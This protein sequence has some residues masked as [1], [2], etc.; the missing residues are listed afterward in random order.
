MKKKSLTKRIVSFITAVGLTLTSTVMLI[1]ASAEDSGVKTATI[2][3]TDNWSRTLDYSEIPQGV[4]KTAT[5]TLASDWSGSIDFTGVAE[6]NDT[7]NY[8]TEPYEFQSWDDESTPTAEIIAAIETAAGVDLPEYPTIYIND[9]TVSYN[10]N[11][12]PA[13]GES[14][15]NVEVTIN[16]SGDDE[17]GKYV[18]DY[19]NTYT[20]ESNKGSE[21]IS[22]SQLTNK[23]AIVNPR[24]L[25]INVGALGK[26][27]NDTFE[28]NVTEIKLDVTYLEGEHGAYIGLYDDEAQSGH[29][30]F[31]AHSPDEDDGDRSA[32]IVAAIKEET[33]DDTQHW[34][35]KITGMSVDYSWNLT[36][37]R[38]DFMIDINPVMMGNTPAGTDTWV[39]CDY[40]VVHGKSYKEITTEKTGTGTFTS[41]DLFNATNITVEDIHCVDLNGG[42]YSDDPDD[43]L[44]VSVTSITLDVEYTIEKPPVEEYISYEEM[45][46]A[47]YIEVA[48]NVR[49]LEDCE[50]DSHINEDSGNDDAEGKTYCPWSGFSINKVDVNDSWSEN[51]YDMWAEDN[52]ISFAEDGSSF[53]V[54]VPVSSVVD[55]LGALSSGEQYVISTGGVSDVSYEIYTSK[56]DMVLRTGS[57]LSGTIEYAYLWDD[58]AQGPVQQDYPE[59][60]PRFVISENPNAVDFEGYAALK[61]DYTATNPTAARGIGILF[62]GWDENGIGWVEK[63]FAM[64]ENGTIAIDLTSDMFEGKSF[65]NIHIGP[66]A[67]DGAQVGDTLAPGFAVTSA[68]IVTSYDGEFSEEL[69]PEVDSNVYLFAEDIAGKNYLRVTANIKLLTECE[70]ESHYDENYGVDDAIG[71]TYCPWNGVNIHKINAD[72]EWSDAYY[73]HWG[74][75]N[76][77]V[78]YS[79]DKSTA[80]Y[81]Y[82]IAGIIDA[83]GELEEGDKYVILTDGISSMTYELLESKPDMTLGT[84]SYISGTIGEASEWDN[85]TNST[86]N[87]GIPEIYPT[88]AIWSTPD[89]AV[90]LNG[91]EALKIDYTATNPEAARGINL[92]IQG[93]GDNSTEWWS[94]FYAIEE[95]GSIVVDLSAADLKDKIFYNI[96]VGPVAPA[97]AEIGDTFAP[98]FTVTSAALLASYDGTFSEEIEQPVLTEYAVNCSA[99]ANGTVTSDFEAAPIGRTVTLTLTPDEG[100]IVETVT[101]MNGE[102][103]VET[104]KVNSKT[105]TFKMPANDVTVTAAFVEGEESAYTVSIND[106]TG[107]TITATYADT[108]NEGKVVEGA[109]VTLSV[110]LTSGYAFNN[111][112]TVTDANGSAVTVSIEKDANNNDV[113]YFLMPASDV[114]VTGTYYE[115][116]VCSW[117]KVEDGVYTL[118]TTREKY[119]GDTV[120]ALDIELAEGKTFADVKS[121]KV[122]FEVSEGNWAGGGL[123]A[124]G[125]GEASWEQVG[126]S[127]PDGETCGTVTLEPANGFGTNDDAKAEFQIWWIGAGTITATVSIEYK[128]SGSE[129]E[130]TAGWVD[131]EDGSYTYTSVLGLPAEGESGEGKD[132]STQDATVL[133]IDLD[134]Y[135]QEGA[136]RKYISK[137]TADIEVNGD[138]GGGLCIS[139]KNSAEG[140][141]DGWKQAEVK[142]TGTFTLE[143]PN[144]VYSDA[145]L[146]FMMWFA[147]PDTSLTVSNI[148]LEYMEIIPAGWAGDGEGTYTYTSVLGLPNEDDAEGTERDPNTEEATVLVIDLDEYLE[149]GK[150]RQDIAKLTA[151]FVVDDGIGGGFCIAA[152][153]SAE[154][155]EDGWTEFTVEKSGTFSLET[156]YGVSDESNLLFLMWWAEADT[157][158]TISNIQ[159]EYIKHEITIDKAIEG[160]TVETAVDAAE[161]G[162]TVVITVKPDEG[163]KLDR[164]Y[165]VYTDEIGEEQEIEAETGLSGYEFEMPSAAVEI[166]AVFV[167]EDYTLN[168]YAN[169]D[170]M[171]SVSVVDADGFVLDTAQFGDTVYLDY[172]VN[173]NYKFVEWNV[174]EGN[175]KIEDAEG[176]FDASFTMPAGN[177][178]IEAVFRELG[179]YEIDIAENENGTVNVVESA[180][181]D[182]E[183][184]FTVNA[185]EGYEIDQVTYSYNKTS[186]G[187]YAD[188]LEADPDDGSYTFTMPAAD[189]IISVSYKAIDY[190]VTVTKSDNGTV[191]T[192]AEDNLANI[193]DV[194]TITIEPVEGYKLVENSIEVLD[195]NDIDVDFEA[196]DDGT[197][198][199][200]MPASDVTITAEFEAIDYKVSVETK[201]EGVVEADTDIANIGNTVTFTATPD[202]SESI[203]VVRSV[204]VTYTRGDE[205][206]E[207][208][209]AKDSTGVYAFTMPAADVTISVVFGEYVFVLIEDDEAI[210]FADTW[211]EIA[212]LIEDGE[213]T[214]VVN[215]DYEFG[216]KFA[217]PKNAQSLTFTGEGT[218]T[219]TG[220]KFAVPVDTTF[221]AKVAVSNKTNLIDISVAKDCT[222]ELTSDATPYENS[223]PVQFINKITGT[224]TSKLFGL[225]LVN[226]IATF[227]EVN[228]AFEEG[229]LEVNGGKAT[230]IV[231]LGG[232]FAIIG[233]KATAAITEVADGAE[234][235]L[236]INNTVIP[237]VTIDKFGKAVGVWVYDEDK[238]MTALPSGTTILSSKNPVPTGD[239]SIIIENTTENGEELTAYYY[240]KTKEIKAEYGEALYLYNGETEIGHYPNFELLL[241]EITD[242][243]VDYTIEVKTDLTL[244]EKFALPK[245][246]GSITFDGAGTLTFTGTKL[247]VPYDVTIGDGI[248]IDV[249]NKKGTFDIA[250]AKDAKLTNEGTIN[251]INKLSGTKTSALVGDYTAAN[252][253]TFELVDGEITVNGGKVTGIITFDGVLMI[254]GAKA[255]AAITTVAP[256]S[257][258]LLVKVNNVLPKV[259][260]EGVGGEN[261]DEITVTVLNSFDAGDMAELESGT[262]ILYTKKNDFTGKLAIGNDASMNA[263][264]YGKEIK[265]EY[266]DAVTVDDLGTEGDAENANLEKDYP[267]FESAVAA[268]NAAKNNTANY[269]ITINKDI[270]PAKF[271]LPKAAE[272]ITLSGE[273][274]TVN[275]GKAT[276]ITANTDLN[277][278]GITFVTTGKS[279]TLNAKK[280]LTV[281][282]IY[283]DVSAIKGSAKFGLTWFGYEETEPFDITGFGTVEVLDTLKIGKN[284]NVTKLILGT[285]DGAS[286]LLVS[287]V[288]AK[289][290]IKALDAA[291]GGVIEYAEG[292]KIAL[293]FTGKP[294]DFVVGDGLTITGAVA[295]GQ[296]VLATDKI[297]VTDLANGVIPENADVE[298]DF[299][300]I[301]KNICY[302]GKV[303]EVTAGTEAEPTAYALWS[304][305]VA[306]MNNASTEYTITLLDDY[307]ENGAVKFPKTGTYKSVRITSDGEAKNFNFSGNLTLTADTTFEDVNIGAVKN[308][309]PVKYTINAG[310]N[311]VSL[312]NCGTG[313]LTSVSGTAEVGLYNITAEKVKA[314]NLTMGGKIVAKGGITAVNV[315][316]YATGAELVMNQ[317]SKLAVS[318]NIELAPAENALGITATI[319]NKTTGETAVLKDGE[320]IGT[321]KGTGAENITLNA[322]KHPGFKVELVKGKLVVKTVA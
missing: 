93:W 129:P 273:N 236:E 186:G 285:S 162:E 226:N 179:S 259:T 253:A 184:T 5:A 219:F 81:L 283:G 307:T 166:R 16:P 254:G 31:T 271:E 189:V 212:E 65:N 99:A 106:V 70:H 153:E 233:D 232:T 66:L 124:N 151:D 101:V 89:A 82:P 201:G 133:V 20:F 95:S 315:R 243:T 176:E 218:L 274:V 25:W 135:I 310:K 270:A 4:E 164:V 228:V 8:I 3:L 17:S 206:I 317:G 13:D 44:T 275:V 6:D 145:D 292:A 142:E 11:F 64:E 302:M 29:W 288:A 321:L 221:D 127:T 91:Y 118:E 27:P 250:V 268:I 73:N 257:E 291:N 45:Q 48:A 23:G 12:T 304:E 170:E 169:D 264:L 322:E 26:N 9:I 76:N 103:E 60:F 132:P 256:D 30:H 193:G 300:K 319:L 98:G 320:A 242:E 229:Y 114:T 53:T 258:I 97:D 121:I 37:D 148:Q 157:S 289:A 269:S 42:M 245:K 134:E 79:E 281:G 197:Y 69:E 278:G 174:I 77:V 200:E 119:M 195:G 277:L 183:V 298:Y 266:G 104:T 306:V 286:T 7:L 141:D 152:N 194:I 205:T 136:A 313:L 2:T 110:E 160:G 105:Y 241:E 161:A 49:L 46:G 28:F 130:K 138:L 102:E 231:K 92:I 239:D 128:E 192:D 214:I 237:K 51:N 15:T 318:G 112:Y 217:L 74:F 140:A 177:V 158:L 293:A 75:T 178:E 230:G 171:G 280:N 216:T 57:Y 211:E 10:W 267:N 262:A 182:A 32:D 155:A 224:K 251:G 311:N 111:E 83:V 296:A 279:L 107:G 50:H 131:N 72:D 67:P 247:T 297:A 295:N 34:A 167:K 165:A 225:V 55:A 115:A 172:D 301:G 238:H 149:D 24:F 84:G 209:T 282:T 116:M 125:V 58:E 203:Y 223:K 85:E 240:K 68:S 126:W 63:D 38:T 71:A 227:G 314:R 19:S 96:Y 207:V 39:T 113:Y 234:I 185:D 287:D 175:V 305:V 290:S 123:G 159:L 22:F 204:K 144:G 309:T 36:T 316:P 40:G 21:T 54:L 246:A 188:T 143:T 62:E 78:T 1:P 14:V 120:P 80:V 272:A 56:P 235:I 191:K 199:F 180:K 215:K 100:Y 146:L 222:L 109:K 260:L 265:A 18:G 299:V 47:Q 52:S 147:S 187:V 196:N 59:L 90:T 117:T 35:V 255:S 252:L 43:E 294:A 181:E 108:D 163:Y 202:T 276:A 168:V 87:I 156:P 308:G 61:I 88:F 86:V 33:G 94:K 263:Y 244:D 173:D 213:Y 154:G 210:G 248:T 261:E 137:I 284:F 150:T 122:D 208:K 198:S 41:T 312:F 139:A 190:K 249:S 220:T 303:L